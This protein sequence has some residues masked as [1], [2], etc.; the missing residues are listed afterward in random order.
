VV[1]SGHPWPTSAYFCCPDTGQKT[2][3]I[4]A[5]VSKNEYKLIQFFFISSLTSIFFT[6]R[7]MTA[8]TPQDIHP[9]FIF[10]FQIVPILIASRKPSVCFSVF[11]PK[12]KLKVQ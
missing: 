12:I 2:I 5:E 8:C 3:T 9:A 1:L 10:K 6:E 11:H 7:Q 4:K